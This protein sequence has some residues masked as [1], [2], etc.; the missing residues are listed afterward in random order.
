MSRLRV[1]QH[2]FY[3]HLAVGFKHYI[4][5]LLGQKR[6]PQIWLTDAK[7]SHLPGHRH[8]R[9]PQR[10]NRC[11][12]ATRLDK[13]LVRRDSSQQCPLRKEILGLSLGSPGHASG[14]E[15]AL[16][17]QQPWFCSPDFGQE[18]SWEMLWVTACIS[19]YA[20]PCLVLNPRQMTQL[21]EAAWL[22]KKQVSED[23]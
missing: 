2:A 3:L 1:P 16:I 18:W 22:S 11:H 5:K 17:W 9:C 7:W 8:C 6:Q 10:P 23:P 15:R 21:H 12:V 19:S 4:A 14:T 13:P 20:F